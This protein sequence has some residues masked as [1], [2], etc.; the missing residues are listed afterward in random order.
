MP[1]TK[2]FALD[3]SHGFSNFDTRQLFRLAVSPLFWGQMVFLSERGLNDLELISFNYSVIGIN[4]IFHKHKK[5]FLSSSRRKYIDFLQCFVPV[6]AIHEQKEF[7]IILKTSVSV[8][9][10]TKLGVH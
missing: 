3:H 6:S 5:L 1:S 10:F 2:D 7:I 4:H 9:M 8:L